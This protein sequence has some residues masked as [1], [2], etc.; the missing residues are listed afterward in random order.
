MLL[1]LLL[2]LPLL[3]SVT[4]FAIIIAIAIAIVS[5]IDMVMAI[6]TEIGFCCCHELLLLGLSVPCMNCTSA[7]V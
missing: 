5:T 7:N 6:A 2:F 3:I 1:T 4:I